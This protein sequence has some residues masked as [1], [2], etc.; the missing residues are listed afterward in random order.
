M[1]EG[2]MRWYVVHT[3][4]GME[5]SAEAGL[6]ERIKRAE[7]Q[8]YFGEILVPTEDVAEVR[9]GKKRVSTRRMYSG[10]IFV[11]MIM[12][13]ET[14]HLVKNTA[15]ITGFLGGQSNRPSPIP[16]SEIDSIKK[17]M[18]EGVEAPRPRVAFEVGET[19]RIKDGAFA[20]FNGVIEDVNY[21]KS[22]L[23][24]TVSIFGRDTPVELGFSEVDK[25]I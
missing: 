10:Y 20:D 25:E 21:D 19:V 15:R 8:D 11:N 5:K 22:K 3:Y 14:W 12:N 4:S 18:E 9:N 1:A 24:V 17:R 7:L 23:R 13:D 16:Q 2:A 6:R